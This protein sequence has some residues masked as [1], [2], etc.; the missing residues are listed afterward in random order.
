MAKNFIITDSFTAGQL[1]PR[2]R[3]RVDLDQYNNGV[4][5]LSNFTL[6][7]HGGIT[8]RT[9]TKFIAEVKDSSAEVRLIHFQFSTTQAYI[10]ELGNLYMRFYRDQAQILD[11]ETITNGTFDTDIA[12]WTDNSV[13]SGAIA[14]NGVANAMDLIAA[15]SSDFG[16]AEQSLTLGISQY[17]LTLDVIDQTLTFNIGTTSGAGDIATGTVTAGLA[18]TINFT[19]SVKGTVFISLEN[20]NAS[21]T[22]KVD[23]I[24]ISTPI[25]EIDT[26]YTTAQLEAI[27]FA[28]SADVMYL[29]HSAHEVREL[30][31]TGHDDWT[32]IEAPFVDGPYYDITHTTYGGTGSTIT[33]NPSGTTG[34]VTL[35][36]SAALFV[37]TDVGRDI[38]YRGLTSEEW[39]WATITAFGSSTSVT[40]LIVKDFTTSPASTEWRLGSWSDTTG[41]PQSTTFHEQRLYFAAT[42]DQ[43]QTLWG[44]TAGLI[45]DFQPD[46]SD[47]K[48]AVDDDTAVTFTIASTEANV[49]HWL[50]SRRSLFL[51]TSGNIF[52]AEASNNFEA[53]T[54]TNITIRPAVGVDCKQSA[55]LTTENAT[56]FVHFFGKKLMELAFF[57]D[58][59]SFR[60]TDL[61][62]L[63][64]DVTSTGIKYMA[65]QEEPDNIIW[66]VTDDGKLIGLTYLRRQKVVGWHSHTIGGT[67]VSVEAVSTIPGSTQ[68]EVWISVKRTIDGG[69][70]RYVEVVTETFDETKSDMWFVDSGLEFTSTDSATITAITKANP[71]VVTTSGN[72]GFSDGDTVE[73][74]SVVG[75][76]EVNGFSFIIANKTATTFELKNT[77]TSSNTTYSSAGTALKLPLTISG[78]DHLE[79]ETVAMIVN[80]ATHPTKVVS[81]G[82]IT[83]ERGAKTG[84]FG[85]AYTSDVE[86]NALEART[87]L[88]TIQGSVG[89]VYKAILRFHKTL[90]G[91]FG[92]D[93]SNLDTILFRDGD[94]TMDNSPDL[95]TGDKIL[96]FPRGQETDQ[97]IYIRQDQP[98]P[99][100]ILAIVAKAV[101]SDA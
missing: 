62:I 7:P 88:G 27:Q 50:N 8:R 60:A 101:I 71:G 31:R 97:I 70:K 75:M 12:G 77:D 82:S 3:G 69:T 67:S 59:D 42:S 93:S 79:G 11:S 41:F 51:G 48:D 6:H 66:G 21:T 95:F 58:D 78:L 33:I 81:S 72:H 83:L 28:Q 9:G 5:T 19:P 26:P 22:G 4:R 18:K 76:T 17:T 29:C 100:T 30:S 37:S 90:G 32:L 34:S 10:L 24:S 20:Q 68:S 85:L 73:I 45:V 49:I 23:N 53:I 13:G 63:A 14:H 15:A 1:S 25:Y 99:M 86:T 46:N 35:V 56:L 98:L 54:P 57:F 2:L 16:I 40:A 38:R 47:Y 96:E 74:N 52:S 36:A 64:E 55:A 65:K 84:V 89:R 43:P 39:G 92:Y 87:G 94:D 44:S 80:E 61:T 91:K